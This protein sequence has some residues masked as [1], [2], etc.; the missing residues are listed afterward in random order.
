VRQLLTNVGFQQAAEDEY[1]LQFETMPKE[2]QVVYLLFD[3]Q[4]KL[5]LEKS[6]RGLFFKYNS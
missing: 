6:Y 1:L 2:K 3:Y 4:S 5:A